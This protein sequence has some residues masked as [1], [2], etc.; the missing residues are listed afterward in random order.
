[1]RL[2]LIRNSLFRFANGFRLISGKPVR[3]L[4]VAL[5]HFLATKTGKQNLH[6]LL[7]NY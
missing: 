3:F 7:L 4:V 2:Q 1:M 5:M 6:F